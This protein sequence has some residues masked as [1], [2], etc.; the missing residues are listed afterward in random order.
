MKKKRKIRPA[1]AQIAAARKLIDATLVE[2]DYIVHC[3][4]WDGDTPM[5]T[6]MD[7]EFFD[8]LQRADT[9]AL[10]EVADCLRHNQSAGICSR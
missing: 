6:A 7:S 5:Y 10:F 9:D 8:Y 2:R 1:A 4:G 3:T